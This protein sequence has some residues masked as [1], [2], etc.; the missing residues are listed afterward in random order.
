MSG[1]Q[2]DP[3]L[4]DRIIRLA[5]A[6]AL[7]ATYYANVIVLLANCLLAFAVFP[8]S[9]SVWVFLIDYAVLMLIELDVGWLWQ[10]EAI[11]ITDELPAIDWP[12]L[13]I[14]VSV[15]SWLRWVQVGFNVFTVVYF[16]FGYLLN[17][18]E[19]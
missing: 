19:A 9:S 15:E 3:D 7:L 18:V 4:C 1:R 8:S 16:G 13:A 14:F 5:K 10:Y 11:D 2:L 17:H 6:F 12:Q